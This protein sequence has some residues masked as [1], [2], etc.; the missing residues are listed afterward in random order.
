[1]PDL[2]RRYREEVV[3]ALMREFEYQ[4]IMQVPGLRRW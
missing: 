4:N 2:K 3:P 1:M